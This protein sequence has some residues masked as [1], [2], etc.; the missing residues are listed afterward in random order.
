[1]VKRVKLPDGSTGEFPDSMDDDAIAGVLQKQFPPKAPEPTYDPSEGMSPVEKMLV[2]A[3]SAMDKTYR[4]VRDFVRPDGT[5]S[6]KER[7]ERQAERE[8]AKLYQKHHPG[9]WATAGEVIGDIAA[10]APVGGALSLGAKALPAAGRLAAVGG[11]ML[12]PGTVGRAATEAGVVAAL[13]PPGEDESRLGNAAQGAALGAALPAAVKGVGK[14]VQA[15]WNRFSD[16]GAPIRATKALDRTLGKDVV[17]DA[18]DQ[19]SNPTPTMFPLTTAGVTQNRRMGAL[20]AG[21]RQRGTAN[22]M[23]HDEDV[24]KQSWAALRG[25][26]RSALGPTRAMANMTP[27]AAQEATE[28]A[29]R[30]RGTFSRNGFPTSPRSFGQVSNGTA[31]PEVQ[32]RALRRTLAQ[33]AGRMESGEVVDAGRIADELGRHEIYKTPNAAGS[34]QL[35]ASEA[36]GIATGALAASKYWRALKAITPGLK[37]ADAATQRAV[38]Q[39]LL[40]PQSFLKMVETQR[41]LGRPLEGW[42]ANL[43]NILTGAQSREIGALSAGEE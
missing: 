19:I 21:A 22:F 13:Q 11:R 29:A 9:G 37:R 34:A 17:D 3:G 26:T 2:G 20:E 38:D 39:A 25:A 8:D 18:V 23:G 32:E 42:Q 15:A 1:M 24:A 6:Y 36:Q 35:G 40:D 41:A 10:T 33:N 16:S 7:E 28:A 12:N 14:G 31:V 5:L 27:E 43:R 4:G 30:V